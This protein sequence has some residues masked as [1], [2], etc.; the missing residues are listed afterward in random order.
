MVLWPIFFVAAS[1]QD[2]HLKPRNFRKTMVK[3]IE[4]IRTRDSRANAA[5]EGFGAR[6]GPHVVEETPHWEHQGENV[7]SC[8]M[9]YT[10]GKLVP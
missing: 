3:G 10:S 2:P 1:Q 6:V 4:G 7:R 5:K 9:Y 8:N